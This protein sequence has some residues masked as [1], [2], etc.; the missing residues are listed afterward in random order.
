MVEKK[1]PGRQ[2]ELDVVKGIAMIMVILVH[3]NQSYESNIPWF[4]FFQMGCQV[5]FVIAGYGGAA[6]F[7]KKLR[8]QSYGQAAKTFLWSRI[9]GIAPAWYFMMVITYL[10][11]SISVWLTGNLLPI[12][13]NRNPLAILCNAL[14]IQGLIPSYNNNVMP[15]GWYIGTIMVLYVATPL[16]F[17][18]LA[19]AQ[20]VRQK[21]GRCLCVSMAAFLL[22]IGISVSVPGDPQMVM[23]NNSF[24]YFS[25]L[26]QI[27]CYL[28]GMLLFFE[29]RDNAAVDKKENVRKGVLAFVWMVVAVILFFN[30]VI[31]YSYIL[32]ASLVGVATF[33]GLQWIMKKEKGWLYKMIAAPLKSIGRKTLYIY[34]VHTYFA[35]IFVEWFQKETLRIGLDSDNYVGFFL[36]I[37][38]V[39]LASYIFGELVQ[40]TVARLSSCFEKKWQAAK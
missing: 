37:P 12:G 16:L 34:L 19:T 6:S 22:L 11:N 3:Y 21:R 2:E 26:T 28:L 14:F 24:W 27:P 15:G 36:L 39:I 4:R 33:F 25:P 10:A 20:T 32:D 7:S 31:W 35:W 30:P 8:N 38:V 18:L 29:T 40:R 1:L 17:Y 9:W 5:F 23:G 13:I